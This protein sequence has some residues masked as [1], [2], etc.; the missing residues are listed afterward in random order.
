MQ[1]KRKQA[2]LEEQEERKRKEQA[3]AHLFTVIKVSRDKE[4]WEQIRSDLIFDLVDLE[5][6]T[7][8]RLPN[9]MCFVDF[10]REV[11]REVGVPVAGQRFWLWAHWQNHTYRP[12]RPLNPVEEGMTYCAAFANNRSTHS[13]GDSDVSPPPF[14]PP[15]P[16]P[17]TLQEI[18]FEPSVMC[19]ALDRTVT[20]KG[21]QL[22]DGDIVCVQRAKP[23]AP[24]GAAGAARSGESGALPTAG[25]AQRGHVLLG[26]VSDL[27]LSPAAWCTFEMPGE[28]QQRHLLSASRWESHRV[29]HPHT[30][31]NYAAS[32]LLCYSLLHPPCSATPCCIIPDVLLLAASS[33]LLCYSLLHPP[34]FAS[35]CCILLPALLLPAASSLLCFSLLHPPPCSATPC[36]ILP[37]VLLPAASSSL[38]C[39]SLLHPPC[40]A[41]IP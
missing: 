16:F 4:L 2:D 24:E 12:N 8:F 25:E 23:L 27:L 7:S 22:E 21:A 30:G 37:A 3:E 29:P 17:P 11:E 28:A 9:Q 6:V 34:C 20:F 10:Q 15:L 31:P 19:K 14:P 5:H 40:C 39:Y 35:P 33:S 13:P 38:L 36:C 1:L 18:K 32:S 26:A 41:F